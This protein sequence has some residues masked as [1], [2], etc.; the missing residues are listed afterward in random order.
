MSSK[1]FVLAVS[2]VTVFI[3]FSFIFWGLIEIFYFYKGK[4]TKNS[5]T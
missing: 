3:L 2:M 4:K 1:S 5:K